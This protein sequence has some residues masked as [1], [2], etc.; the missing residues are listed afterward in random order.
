MSPVPDIAETLI[1]DSVADEQLRRRVNLYLTH[2]GHA[3]VRC[4]RVR[5]KN[6]VIT[7]RGTVPSCYVRQL[8][9]ACTRRVAGVRQVFDEI[10]VCA[11]TEKRPKEVQQN[12]R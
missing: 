12:V 9:L 1:D 11:K 2:T 3:P 8:A 10:E 6:G 5:A 7:L 4:L